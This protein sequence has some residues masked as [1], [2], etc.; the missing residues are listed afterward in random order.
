MKRIKVLPLF[1]LLLAIG[2]LLTTTKSDTMHSWIVNLAPRTKA[3]PP[4]TILLHWQTENA[5]LRAE[6]E[7]LQ[8]RLALLRSLPSDAPHDPLPAK[9]IFRSQ[10]AWNSALWINVGEKDNRDLGRAVVMKMSPVI[11]GE[12]VVG[13]ID[14]VGEKQSRVRL[15]TDS[16]LTPAVRAVRREGNKTL[17]LA[18]GIVRGDTAPLFRAQEHRLIGSGF[19]Y[20]FADQAGPARPLESA[21]PLVQKGDLLLTT[22]MDGV[23]PPG[24]SVGEVVS[25]DSLQEGDFAFTLTARPTMKSLN[26]LSVL[27]VI[28]PL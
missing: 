5:L 11:L 8:E 27:F 19:N 18:K 25:V 14:Y 20:D 4:E 3:L 10:D 1:L 6:I 22:G 16:T 21:P 26:Q 23:F 17:H 9:V 2:L 12:A 13:I 7:G 28:P 15:L 24:L